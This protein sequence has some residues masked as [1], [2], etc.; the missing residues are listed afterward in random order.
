MKIIEIYNKERIIES[1][2][3]WLVLNKTVLIKFFLT[4]ALYDRSKLK[5]SYLN[6]GYKIWECCSCLKLMMQDH[7][8]VGSFKIFY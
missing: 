1:F 2:K 7:L 3:S 5:Y 4:G 6:Q 8:H